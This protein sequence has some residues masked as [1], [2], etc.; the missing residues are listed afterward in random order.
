MKFGIQSSKFGLAR[1]RRAFTLLEVLLAMFILALGLASVASIFPA[2]SYLQGQTANQVITRHVI[3]STAG[4]ITE[5]SLDTTSPVTFG[6][7]SVQVFG[8]T[9]ATEWPLSRRCYPLIDTSD[10]NYYNRDY[11]WVP[12]LYDNGTTAM[13][14]VF[15][16]QK[17]TGINYD[18]TGYHSSQRRGVSGAAAVNWANQ[19]DGDDSAGTWH[20]PG[21]RR[22]EVT[23]RTPTAHDDE[24]DW[25]DIDDTDENEINAEGDRIMPGM[26]LLDNFGVVHKVVEANKDG[27]RV[28]GDVDFSVESIWYSPGPVPG[29][30]SPTV[31]IF[32]LG[33]S[34]LQ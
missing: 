6:S 13:V 34:V 11:Y 5:G 7:E 20:V 14:F 18:Y 22:V 9:Y 21:V 10:P 28:E 16:L 23:H 26:L 27:F 25:V 30:A 32:P 2:A 17:Q 33:A 3:D 15:V 4:S 31:H 8:A 19:N 12:L 24:G 1:R 29:S